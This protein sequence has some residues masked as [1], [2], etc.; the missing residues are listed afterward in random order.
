[1]HLKGPAVALFRALQGIAP[2]LDAAMVLNV[3]EGAGL[4]VSVRD[5]QGRP[6]HLSDAVIDQLLGGDEAGVLRYFDEAGAELGPDRLPQ[7]RVRR[8]GE[9]VLNTVVRVEGPAGS[10][11]V[12][13]SYTALAPGDGGYSVLG[14]GK[15]VTAAREA[16]IIL[17]RMATHDGLTGLRN[18]G[19]LLAQAE[20]WFEA[21]LASGAPLAVAL[22]DIDH[23][24]AVNDQ[25]GHAAGD[26][27]LVAVAEAVRAALPPEA[28][29]GRW[30][31]EEFLVVLPDAPADRA[32]AVAERLR[33]AVAAVGAASNESAAG[34]SLR[35]TAS[36]G[37]AAVPGPHPTL[38]ALIGQADEALYVA[39]RDGRDRVATIAA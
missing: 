2:H 39:K 33:V 10:M 8:T 37:V 4:I 14:I 7:E 19:G 20:P 25:H 28:I 22:L 17:E 27:V 6:L 35:V 3:C 34:A 13:M 18:R 24:K 29:A 38:H 21:A 36:V 11:W 26:A 23:F 32:F 16:E 31:G 5:D 1:L 30:G 12:Q 9:D 15:D